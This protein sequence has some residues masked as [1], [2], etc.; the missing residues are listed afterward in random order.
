MVPKYMR[1]P[2]GWYEEDCDWCIPAL[3]FPDSGLDNGD[4]KRT[5]LNWHPDAYAKF[6]DVPLESLE[7]KSGEYD[8]RLWKQR[9]AD[10]WQTLS[11]WG[12]WHE[13]VPE[14]KVGVVACIGG[15]SEGPPYGA[16][17]EARYFLVDGDEYKARTGTYVVDPE[18]AEDWEP[19]A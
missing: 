18:T 3:V 12:D 19:H 11:A 4:A 1:M 8:R 9:N 16:Q 7:G 13:H 14:G 6:Y 5:L 10:K 2:G 17:G 15:R